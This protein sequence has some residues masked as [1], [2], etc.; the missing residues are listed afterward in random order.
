M[1]RS[2]RAKRW[3]KSYHPILLC[4]CFSSEFQQ[5]LRIKMQ[6]GRCRLAKSLIRS[7]MS[8]SRPFFAAVAVAV[9]VLVNVQRPNICRTNKTV[10]LFYWQVLFYQ[11][12]SRINV[13]KRIHCSHGIMCGFSSHSNGKVTF[14]FIFPPSS[15]WWR[16]LFSGI[17]LE[18]HIKSWYAY[19]QQQQCKTNHITNATANNGSKIFWPVE[20]FQ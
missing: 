9:I 10:W 15:V 20:I 12:R 17:F 1:V 4:V 11:F 13:Q 18:F 16:Y 14:H 19:Q 6:N 8:H 3:L 2:V 5:Y 7:K